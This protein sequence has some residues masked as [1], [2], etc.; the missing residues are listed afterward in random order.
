MEGICVP[1]LG[2]ILNQKILELFQFRHL[3]CDN[4]FS[5]LYKLLIFL[6]ISFVQFYYNVPSVVSWY[7]SFW[8]FIS[9]YIYC[10]LL[11]WMYFTNFGKFLAVISSN[12]FPQ[13]TFSLLSCNSSYSCVTVFAVVPQI[14]NAL[15]YFSRCFLIGL[16]LLTC[17]HIH[18]FLLC[19]VQSINKPI[20]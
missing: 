18:L 20:K 6:I 7:L 19:Y 11:G 14:S 15:F 16:L 13:P 12:I 1:V 8:G 9:R 3:I 5:F 17:F 10:G 4:I 2:E